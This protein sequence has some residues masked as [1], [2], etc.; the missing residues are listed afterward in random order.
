MIDAFYASLNENS[1]V[2]LIVLTHG[3]IGTP[4]IL[5]EKH[6]REVYRIS[7]IPNGICNVFNFMDTTKMIY[8]CTQENKDTVLTDLKKQMG[9][10]RQ[11][12]C[13]TYKPGEDDNYKNH[14]ERCRL[15]TVD[16]S[17]EKTFTTGNTMF[18]KIFS[19][20][21]DRDGFSALIL[22]NEQTGKFVNLLQNRKADLNTFEL[23]D[24]LEKLKICK[25]VTFIDFSCTNNDGNKYNQHEL[26]TYGGTKKHQIKAFKHKTRKR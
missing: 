6:A 19:T 18:N 21:N 8:M 2:R 15:F 3:N 14:Y 10:S 20:D 24:I 17:F 4:E 12:E 22:M 9:S 25:K 26:D 11:H 5:T 13:D 16:T 23:F 1:T 7:M